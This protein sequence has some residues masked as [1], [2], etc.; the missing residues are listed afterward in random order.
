M[1]KL[2]IYSIDIIAVLILVIISICLLTRLTVNKDSYNRWKPFL[3][4]EQQFDVLFFGNSHIIDSVYPMELW[5]D[6]GIHSYN[7]GMHG[8]A[9]PERYW[10][11]MNALEYTNPKLVVIDCFSIEKNTVGSV[12]NMHIAFDALPLTT[13]KKAAI[14]DLLKDSDRKAEFFCKFV[15][16]HE[17]WMDI[18]KGDFIIAGCKGKGADIQTGV[19]VPDAFKLIDKEQKM[20]EDTM[21]VEYLEK[22]IQECQKRNIEVILTYMPFPASTKQQEAANRVGDI[23]EKY[24]VDYLSYQTLLK[25]INLNTD[26]HDSSSHLNASGARKITAYIGAYIIN[27]Y[28]IEDHRKDVAYS[29]W[30]DYYDTYTS[31]K[32]QMI[33]QQDNIESYLMLLSDK[34]L[35]FGIFIPKDTTGFQSEIM[36]ELLNNAGVNTSNIDFSKDIF[37]FRDNITNTCSYVVMGD[38]LKNDFGIIKTYYDEDGCCS[39]EINEKNKVTFKDNEK[40]ESIIVGFVNKTGEMKIL[41]TFVRGSSFLVDD[42]KNNN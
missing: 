25:E 20:T 22:M 17:N 39:I 16:Y 37:V 12:E 40:G 35:S 24:G 13:T 6:Y 3:N 42:K 19:A 38:T 34:N 18:T 27:N 21:G 1:K 11:M 8:T 10:I 26:C 32:V 23:A 14:D 31:Y 33:N 5:N 15:I 41:K 29:S 9:M 30:N 4:E 28:E 36:Q 2:V 7:L